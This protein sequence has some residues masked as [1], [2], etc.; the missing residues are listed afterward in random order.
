MALAFLPIGD[1]RAGFATIGL[2]L[3]AWDQDNQ[4]RHMEFVSYFEETW[5]GTQVKYSR[6][7]NFIIFLF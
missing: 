5:I 7:A 4:D 6:I 3:L 2:E 1:V